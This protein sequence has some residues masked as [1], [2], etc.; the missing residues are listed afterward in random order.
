MV[1]FLKPSAYLVEKFLKIQVTAPF[2]YTAIGA[3]NGDTPVPNFTND[4]NRILL[5]KGEAVYRAACD[6]LRQWQM[7]P[8]GWAWIAPEGAPIQVGQNLAMVAR[9]MGIYWL[10]GCRIVYTL[11]GTGP[12]RRYGFAYG[13]LPDHAECGEERFSIAWL[14]DDTVWYD[15]KAFSQPRHWLARAFKPVARWH[16]RRFV[17]ESLQKMKLIASQNRA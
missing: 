16:Q 5:G 11:D 1:S 9:V 6:A 10:N 2:A 14:D 4:H 12:D 7:F 8:G 17:K 3:T 13:T 15:L